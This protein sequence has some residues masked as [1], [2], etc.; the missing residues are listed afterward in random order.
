[1][2]PATLLQ[3]KH[4]FFCCCRGFEA[5]TVETY[6]AELNKTEEKQCQNYSPQSINIAELTD[7]GFGY[8][9]LGSE[10]HYGSDKL[11]INIVIVVLHREFI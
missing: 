5:S 8:I 9:C 1:M 2:S 10:I 6:A 3:E 4:I 11:Y 7:L